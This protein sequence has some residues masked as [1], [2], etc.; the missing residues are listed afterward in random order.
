MEA[1]RGQDCPP[2][3]IS[4][5]LSVGRSLLIWCGAATAVGVLLGLAAALS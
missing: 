4:F 1:P 2:P 5:D 3:M